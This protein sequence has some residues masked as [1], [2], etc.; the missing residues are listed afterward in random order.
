MLISYNGNKIDIQKGS[1]IIDILRDEVKDNIMAATV[2]NEVRSL[3]YEINED[4]EI[5]LL[6]TS[7]KDGSRV[8]IRGLLYIMSK[9]FKELYPG[10]LLTINYSLSNAM[11]CEVDNLEITEEM[12]QN[13]SKKMKEIID[14]N[15]PI[16]KVLM[17]KKEAIEFYER[18]KV[19]N[20]RLQVNAKP[21]DT[22]T[23]YYCEDYFNYFYGVMPISTVYI[24]LY[25]ILK[26]NSRIFN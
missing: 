17:S 12:I 18:E 10:A 14:K 19:N 25:E 13:I 8:Y 23:L 21:K 9:A 15:L 3:E 16:T 1:K 26:Y 6:D 7:N 2:N 22:I 11:F 20:G 5:K 4:C 24:K